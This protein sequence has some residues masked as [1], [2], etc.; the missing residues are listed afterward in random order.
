VDPVCEGEGSI[1]AAIVELERG[2]NSSLKPCL[3]RLTDVH[4]RWWWCWVW[5]ME[6][7]E[8]RRG[9]C[10]EVDSEEDSGT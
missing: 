8:M 1:L 9:L 2:V 6:W 3:L 7:D 5:W 10:N 4:A